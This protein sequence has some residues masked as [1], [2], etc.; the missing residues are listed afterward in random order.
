MEEYIH[1]QQL[2]VKTYHRNNFSVQTGQF[3]TRTLKANRY[4][5]VM[6]EI[7][8]NAIIVKPMNSQKDEEMIQA[9]E[10]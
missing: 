4:V 10:S 1:K 7:D 6:V 3:P 9:Y 8:S 2:I 5:I